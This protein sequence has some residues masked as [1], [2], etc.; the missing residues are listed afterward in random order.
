MD[1]VICGAIMGR[2]TIAFDYEGGQRVAEPWCLGFSGKGNQ[3]LRAYQIG[4]YS[5]SGDPSGWRLY[6]LSKMG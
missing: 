4:G 3:V 1:S 2:H 5:K 6:D